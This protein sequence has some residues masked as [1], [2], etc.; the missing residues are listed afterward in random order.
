MCHARDQLK[1]SVVA[2]A[3][4]SLL[5]QGRTA[6]KA[7]VGQ[8]MT[9]LNSLRK[10]AKGDYKTQVAAVKASIQGVESAVGKLGN[11][12]VSKNLQ[13]VG[14]AITK[15]GTT[16]GALLSKLK[17][18]AGP[19]LTATTNRRHQPIKPEEELQAWLFAP[20][21]NTAAGRHI[22][23]KAPPFGATSGSTWA[24]WKPH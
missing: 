9:N 22:L 23:E 17:A 14:A 20:R 13:A 16:S 12:Q 5:V 18:P 24:F 4:P 7:A 11:G 8:V 21:S 1:T 19:D 3:K 15:V 2:L 10:A 6:I